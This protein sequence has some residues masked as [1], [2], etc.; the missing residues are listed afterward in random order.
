MTLIFHP[1]QCH[2][3]LVSRNSQAEA[4]HSTLFCTMCRRELGLWNFKP[5]QAS[6]NEEENFPG[7]SL[8]RSKSTARYLTEGRFQQSTPQEFESMDMTQLTSS[9][10]VSIED[11]TDSI[12]T[13]AGVKRTN[14]GYRNTPL[15]GSTPSI[16]I[17]ECMDIEEKLKLKADVKD[18]FMQRTDPEEAN[19]N[20]SESNIKEAGPPR[21]SLL[22]K[23]LVSGR[24]S[25][26]RGKLNT[27]GLPYRS[28]LHSSISDLSEKGHCESLCVEV[29]DESLTE[30]LQAVES[31]LEFMACQSTTDR[32]DYA[33]DIKRIRLEV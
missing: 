32:E 31:E 26:I 11:E 16:D 4:E 10:S 7:S 6:E 5:F 15:A 2:L 9:S 22:L 8:Q 3:G 14:K 23:R 21:E 20:L 25:P 33:P 12:R 28:P 1:F 18:V 24:D 13:F 19:M 29:E 17:E 30:K 27:E